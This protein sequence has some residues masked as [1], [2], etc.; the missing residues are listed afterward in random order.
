L[1]AKIVAHRKEVENGEEILTS[2]LKER[3]KD[4]NNFEA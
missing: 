2:Y 1:E 3:S 4:L